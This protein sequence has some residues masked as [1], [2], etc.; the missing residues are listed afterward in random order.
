MK[1]NKKGSNTPT[2]KKP[3]KSGATK[4]P[5][6]QGRASSTTGKWFFAQIQSDINIGG[7][8]TDIDIAGT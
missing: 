4:K 8:G 1:V 5:K 6:N 2:H 3:K 7:T